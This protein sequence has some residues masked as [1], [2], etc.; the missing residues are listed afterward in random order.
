MKIPKF[1]YKYKSKY[2]K[3]K[4][5]TKA[6][7]GYI[8][9]PIGIINILNPFMSGIIILIIAAKMIRDSRKNTTK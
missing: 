7:I 1:L 9:I 3:I 8:L 5:K 2:N 4:P 6:M